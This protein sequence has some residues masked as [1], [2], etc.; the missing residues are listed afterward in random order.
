MID[1]LVGI[2]RTPD[3][4]LLPFSNG[5]EQKQVDRLWHEAQHSVLVLASDAVSH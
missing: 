5:S 4:N 3:T 2:R 1:S